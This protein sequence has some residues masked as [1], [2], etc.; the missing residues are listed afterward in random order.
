[1][2]NRLLVLVL[3]LSFGPIAVASDVALSAAVM[4][5]A[6]VGSS[7]SPSFSPDGKTLAFVS[8][9]SGLPQIWTIPT[10]GGFPRQVTAL[11]DQIQS[12]TW[13]P[14]GE[15]LAFL[16]AP[17]GGMNS[18]IYLVR[19]DGT[20]MR[21]LTAGGQVNN[22][23]AGWNRSGSRLWLAS[24]ER[25]PAAM[26]A[27]TYEMSSGEL[28]HRANN[29]GIGGASDE[30]PDGRR[31]ILWRVQ[32][33]SDGNLY[34]IDLKSGAEHLLTPHKPPGTFSNGRFLDN[35]T[36]LLASNAERD[37][38]ALGRVKLD[39]DG[40]PGPLE[41]V[42]SHPTGE[43]QS[44][45]LTKD[46]RTGLLIWN[47][48]GRSELAWLDTQTWETRPGPT[49]P[50]E[51]V[52]SATF[53]ADGKQL[54]FVANGA[55][56]PTDIWVYNREADRLTQLTRSPHA[57]VDLEDLVE[58]E[59]VTFEAHDGLTLSGWLYLPP[60]R[61]G[62]VPMVLSFHGGPEGQSRPRFRSDFQA[63]L[64]L[65]IG[66]LDPNVRGSAGFGKRFVNLDNGELRFDGIRDIKACVDY[67]VGEGYANP[68]RL[69]IMGGSYGG[70][71]T[72]AGLAW[73]PY[74]FA[75]GAN[76]FGVV[77]CAPFFAE[78]EPWMAAISK[79][80]YGDPDTQAE[81]LARLSP[82]N[83]LDQVKAPTL[84]LHGQNDTNVPVVEAEQVVDQ[85]KAR[86]V[87]VEYVLFPDEGHG[88]RKTANRV[89][90]TVSIVRWFERYLLA[91]N[92]PKAAP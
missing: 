72:M 64:S 23:L 68:D 77:N 7:S 91:E 48:R 49:V 71:M 76:L 89:T 11:E 39:E 74:M 12:V 81:L 90:S 36:I 29:P 60:E 28:T 65:G 41:V 58:P 84:V 27:Y 9:L 53:S 79:V 47:V 31:A 35:E 70:Y 15:W 22:F 1:M 40:R 61:S 17:G 55:A 6:K 59:L 54:A 42:A 56:R 45:T 69:G 43:L 34:V 46:G 92:A 80:E 8:T 3:L 50:A 19:P 14:D 33:R 16:L 73:Y 32:S 67:V 20:G 66:V 82:I 24:N 21:Q 85:L 57:G 37:L 18:Q 10:S 4:R 88:F 83:K 87:P 51:V 52:Y 5:M 78:T 38:I 25:S 13:S 86:N 75:A 30:S 26:D 2:L 63:L 44:L 62:P